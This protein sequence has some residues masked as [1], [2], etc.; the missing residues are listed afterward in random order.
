MK[1]NSFGGNLFLMTYF[2]IPD[3]LAKKLF[4]FIYSKARIHTIHSLF[5][6]FF[7]ANNGCLQIFKNPTAK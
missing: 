5:A 4:I 7:P 2:M 1:N 3:L 6:T